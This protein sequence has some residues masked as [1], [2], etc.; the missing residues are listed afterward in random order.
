[1]FSDDGFWFMVLVSGSRTRA[2]QKGF[3]LR[4]INQE[5]GTYLYVLSRMRTSVEAGRSVLWKM[6]GLAG[7]GAAST[8]TRSRERA[9]LER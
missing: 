6:W 4:E 1:M 8:A 9:H 7:T 2:K 3:H 5:L